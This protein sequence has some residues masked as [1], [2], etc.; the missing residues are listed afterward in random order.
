ML[1]A[2]KLF[3]NFIFK[4]SHEDFSEME[5]YARHK[6]LHQRAIFHTRQRNKQAKVLVSHLPRKVLCQQYN[7]FSRNNLY[8]MINKFLKNNHPLMHTCWAF[9]CWNFLRHGPLQRMR[10]RLPG[11]TSSWDIIEP[12]WGFII[13][14]VSSAPIPWNTLPL[15]LRIHIYKLK[16]GAQ[17]TMD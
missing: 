4:N 1:S 9:A 15:S 16:P 3:F 13:R 12:F 17:C 7:K 2:S 10:C 14:S 5:Y 8:R 11:F 6:L